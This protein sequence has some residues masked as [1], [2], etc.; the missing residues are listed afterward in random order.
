MVAL[1]PVYQS[2]G[3]L[4]TEPPNSFT[5]WGRPNR[6]VLIA[7]RP[8]HGRPFPLVLSTALELGPSYQQEARH[9]AGKRP[10][11]IPLIFQHFITLV[12]QAR[13]VP[14]IVLI[15]KGT[16][17]VCPEQREGNDCDGIKKCPKK[18][19]FHLV[20]APL[21]APSFLCP[22][23]QTLALPKTQISNPGG[24][25]LTTLLGQSTRSVD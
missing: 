15:Y 24:R 10:R 17:H 8:R 4:S 2:G 18:A 20:G 21:A 6:S 5:G 16:C 9:S 19:A 1:G 25:R 7:R 23:R 12:A 3:E 22:R 13:P 14:M 11:C